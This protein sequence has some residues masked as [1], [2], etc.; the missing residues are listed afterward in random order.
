MLMLVSGQRIPFNYSNY[1]VFFSLMAMPVSVN[2][3][4]ISF[5]KNQEYFCTLLCNIVQ[6][7]L[8]AAE[9][10]KLNMVK[11]FVRKNPSWSVSNKNESSVEI[12][13]V[14]TVSFFKIRAA[15]AF[16][17]SRD[18]AGYTEHCTLQKKGECLC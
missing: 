1:C 8:L 9:S 12:L 6:K 11:F 17:A 15:H 7:I 13:H 2:S 4:W 10:E 16:V 14:F 5:K 3:Q 18:G